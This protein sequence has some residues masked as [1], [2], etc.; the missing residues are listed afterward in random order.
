MCVWIPADHGCVYGCVHGCGANPQ[1]ICGTKPSRRRSQGIEYI[2]M[3]LKG[4]NGSRR[5]STGLLCCTVQIAIMFYFLIM[6]AHNS[7]ADPHNAINVIYC[8]SFLSRKKC[9]SSNLVIKFFSYNDLI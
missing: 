7:E 6:H 5:T 2:K 8:I 4:Y 3:N 1:L 9:V